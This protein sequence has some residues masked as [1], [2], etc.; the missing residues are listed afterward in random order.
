M[1]GL[2]QQVLGGFRRQA[3]VVEHDFGSRE[4]SPKTLREGAHVPRA[5]A[6]AARGVVG[7]SDEESGDGALVAQPRDVLDQFRATA[8]AVERLE[9]EHA[10]PQRIRDRETRAFRAVVDREHAALGSR[11]G[12]AHR[13]CGPSFSRRVT[14]FLTS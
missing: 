8:V 12:R 2:A 5:A 1:T 3:L 11:P 13:N 4:S 7:E 6:L 10:E 9:R 14:I